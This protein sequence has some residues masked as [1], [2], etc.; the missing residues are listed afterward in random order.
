LVDLNTENE[1]YTAIFQQPVK[2]V[3]NP[4]LKE[5]IINVWAFLDSPA[6]DSLD[7]RLTNADF[8]VND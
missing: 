7:R 5:K 8:M 2:E 3:S 4:L 1:I 6:D